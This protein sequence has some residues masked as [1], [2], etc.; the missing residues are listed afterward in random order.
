MY[1]D[2]NN[3][4]IISW[5]LF[6]LERGKATCR[7]NVLRFPL[8]TC[9]KI[10]WSLSFVFWPARVRYAQ[11]IGRRRKRRSCA[12]NCCSKN[13]W[14]SSTSVTSSST[15]WTVKRRRKCLA[16]LVQIFDVKI[17][18]L[19]ICLLVPFSDVQDRRRWSDSKGSTQ[20]WF[21]QSRP[22]LR[23]SIIVGRNY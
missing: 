8:I 4:R 23:D 14:P 22:G 16:S 20:R 1:G 6:K 19:S 13:W 9:N 3:K 7:L 11:Q 17:W 15:T 10:L 5:L 2:R 21:E 18:F 12:K